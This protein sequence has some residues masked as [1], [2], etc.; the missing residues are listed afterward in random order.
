MLTASQSQ[1]L[2]QRPPS[3]SAK[4]NLAAPLNPPAS[5]ALHRIAI[6]RRNSAALQALRV[7]R[8]R[9]RGVRDGSVVARERRGES[10]GEGCWLVLLV[11]WDAEAAHAAFDLGKCK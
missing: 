2:R 3:Q 5:R 11:G 9:R 10:E 6:D 8:E 1:A 7:G 4:T